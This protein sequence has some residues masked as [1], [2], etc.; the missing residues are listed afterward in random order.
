MKHGYFFTGLVGKL[1]QFVFP[2]PVFVPVAATAV[3]GDND[4]IGGTLCFHALR[5][6]PFPD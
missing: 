1:L 6:P 4:L 2:K 5:V 3:G